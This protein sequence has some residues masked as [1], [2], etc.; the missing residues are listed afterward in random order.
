MPRGATFLIA[1]LFVSTLAQ[2]STSLT[3]YHLSGTVTGEDGRIIAGARVAFSVVASSTGALSQVIV[4]SDSSGAYSADFSALPG[5]M[6]GP[7][8]TENAFAFLDRVD[9]LNTDYESDSR[10]ILDPYA[11]DGSSSRSITQNIQLRRRTHIVAGDS[12]LVTISPD[13]TICVNNVQDMHPWPTEFVCRTVRINVPNDGTLTVQAV[14]TDSSVTAGLETEVP[15]TCCLESLDNPRSLFLPAGTEVMAQVE[16]PWGTASSSFWLKTSFAAGSAPTSARVNA[17]GPSYVDSKGQTW[18]ADT[19][20]N[21]GA[22]YS[23]TSSISG[24]SD[25][26]LFQTERWDNATLQYIFYVPNGTYA[27]NLYFAEIWSGCFSVGCRVFNVAVQGTTVFSNLDIFAQVGGNAALVKS[28][29]ASVTSGTL[30][31]TF[32]PVTQNPQINAIEIVLTSSTQT[33]TISGTVTKASDNTAIS[34][35]TVSYSGGATNSNSSGAY[36]LANVVPGTHSVTASASGFQNSTQTNVSVTSGATTTVNFSLSSAVASPPSTPTGLT[37][38]A[39][40]AQVN[41]SWNASSGATSY[42]LYRGTASGGETLLASGIGSTAY[43]DGAVS[44]GTTY[45]YQVSA[46]NSAGES[47]R[48]PEVSA[49][50]SWGT[51]CGAFTLIANPTTLA[52]TRNSSKISTISVSGSSCTLNFTVS[53]S[54]TL[55]GI[56]ASVNPSSASGGTTLTVSAGGRYH[57][58]SGTATVTATDPANANNSA[59]VPVTVSVN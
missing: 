39:G 46:V 4:Y 29:V 3:A 37:A 25:P 20:Y 35:A 17:G 23:T 9:P 40:N 16:M 42:N 53:V 21:G 10:Y 48:S 22:T 28:T 55:K 32:K 24:T 33:G 1:A 36:T 5:A 38:T 57:P 59:S 45:F 49:T 7:V 50:P 52:L 8:G 30:I 58:S 51:G 44:N 54:S 31:I 43:S 14:S 15:G 26:T 19:G 34:G 13:D 27:V 2:S 12:I 18:Q 56:S 47:G 6:V 11:S 41:L